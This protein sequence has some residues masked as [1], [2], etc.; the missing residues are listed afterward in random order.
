MK[1]RY[2]ISILFFLMMFSNSYG[3]KDEPIQLLYNESMNIIKDGFE[4]NYIDS[5]TII[6][7][8]DLE[9]YTAKLDRISLD[10]K[11]LR[12]TTDLRT[13]ENIYYVK[14]YNDEFYGTGFLRS[15]KYGYIDFSDTFI[16]YMAIRINYVD[17]DKSKLDTFS[18][19]R[20]RDDS[21]FCNII[22]DARKKAE[23]II[24]NE[25][26]KAIDNF[27]YFI[28]EENP[29]G[30]EKI[31][32]LKNT[33]EKDLVLLANSLNHIEF[34][35][36]SI[37]IQP[38]DEHL[39]SFE[40]KEE[41]TTHFESSII[42]KY[43]DEQK[44]ISIVGEKSPKSIINKQG[45][46][47]KI[48]YSLLI[49]SYLIILLVWFLRASNRRKKRK[50]KKQNLTNTLLEVEPKNSIL[51]QE[52]SMQEYEGQ[53]A[54]LR[55]ENVNGNNELKALKKENESIS[56]TLAQE[57]T[58][59]KKLLLES[60]K[61]KKRNKNQNRTLS[62][63]KKDL[64]DAN[65]KIDELQI[66][67]QKEKAHWN[68]NYTEMLN[69]LNELK[70]IPPFKKLKKQCIEAISKSKTEVALKNILNYAE[71]QNII[72]LLEMVII[73]SSRWTSLQKKKNAGTISNDDITL[74][75]NNIHSAI[76]NLL[77]K[78]DEEDI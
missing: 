39:F 2:H 60:E 3:Q 10:I 66:S 76:I 29:E 16:R 51:L 27:H 68:E 14:K 42:F 43:G 1:I 37:T 5:S 72:E 4:I 22:I 71:K 11:L 13:K 62:Q 73:Q 58:K 26:K 57:K 20:E 65:L 24:Q 77:V 8:P 25:D 70:N 55:S 56:Q 34:Q 19:Y 7:T 52:N 12:E 33:G 48:L 41:N 6:I 32:V 9:W 49:S 18:I 46:L 67:H 31:L 40:V 15:F 36:S 47:I 75:T 59:N 53:V 23:L 69:E 74:E 17:L 63:L 30:D 45:N 38:N 35:D 64:E 28:N 78:L 21:V 61:F 54:E 44:V 50:F